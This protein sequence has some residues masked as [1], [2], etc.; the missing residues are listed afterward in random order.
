[1]NRK[2]KKL[3][4]NAADSLPTTKWAC[5]LMKSSHVKRCISYFCRTLYFIFSFHFVRLKSIS[6]WHQHTT[7]VYAKNE[8]KMM[9]VVWRNK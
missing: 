7:I 2:K 5:E 8:K 6:S 1:M 4:E 3:N 9:I